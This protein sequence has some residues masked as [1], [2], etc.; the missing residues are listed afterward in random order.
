MSIFCRSN[1]RC[2]FSFPPQVFL[3]DSFY[4]HLHRVSSGLV[5]FNSVA[6]NL[7]S[8]LEKCSTTW[9]SVVLVTY[10]LIVDISPPEVITCLRFSLFL[11]LS[12]SHSAPEALFSFFFFFF[13]AALWHIKFQMCKSH[14]WAASGNFHF[15]WTASSEYVVVCRNNLILWAILS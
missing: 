13:F 6:N 10:H 9:H 11:P 3:I 7:S 4:W 12:L 8:L 5:F 2:F 15:T 1:L 14:G